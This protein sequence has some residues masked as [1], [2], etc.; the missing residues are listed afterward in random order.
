M[1]VFKDWE[2][3]KKQMEQI[4]F[5]LQMQF[6]EKDDWGLRR[7]LSDF[8]LFK[9]GHSKEI[10]NVISKKETFLEEQFFIFDYKY[11][12]QAGNTPVKHYQTVFHIQSKKLG[13]PE[14][15][16]KPE[17]FFHKIGAFLGMQDIDFEEHPEFSQKNL[18]QGEDEDLVRN[19][20]TVNPLLFRFFTV[21]R[22]W[23]LEGVGYF[24]V[25]YSQQKLLHPG[26]VKNFLKK[27]M[28]VYDILKSK[29]EE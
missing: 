21:E 17:S 26:I 6:S 3:R 15:L 23:S 27:G 20:M 1:S 9:K 13:L 2:G 29:E 19:M 24:M 10:F 12:I 8:H 4:A 11:T 14:F 28:E 16:L 25:F 18:L 5:E 7:R 22:D